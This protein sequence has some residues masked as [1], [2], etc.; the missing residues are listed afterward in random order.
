MTPGLQGFLVA[1][2]FSAAKVDAIVADAQARFG[3]VCRQCPTGTSSRMLKH[4][5]L[6]EQGKLR[7]QEERKG[8][9]KVF[10]I[11]DDD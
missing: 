1:A 7:K 5:S 4:R 8:G 11:D 10:Y 2:F 9:G 6:Q 3:L